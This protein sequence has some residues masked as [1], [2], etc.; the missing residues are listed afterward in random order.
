VAVPEAGMVGNI[1]PIFLNTSLPPGDH[2]VSVG[3]GRTTRLPR[4]SALV[5]QESWSPGR[6]SMQEGCD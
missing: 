2:Q 1:F 6:A 4:S 3:F 5:I